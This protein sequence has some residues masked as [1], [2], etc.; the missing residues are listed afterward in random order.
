MRNS[1]RNH[2]PV[3]LPEAAAVEVVEPGT[4]PMTDDQY[5]AAVKALAVLISQ[6]RSAQTTTGPTGTGRPLAA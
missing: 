4:V 1:Y 6:R 5:S 2:R 3:T